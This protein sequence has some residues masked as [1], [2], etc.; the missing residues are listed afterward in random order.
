LRA[1]PRLWDVISIYLNLLMKYGFG[2]A[3]NCNKE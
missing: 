1:L 2:Y 3:T